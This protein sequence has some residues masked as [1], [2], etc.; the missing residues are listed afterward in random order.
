MVRV[1]FGK[2][3]DAEIVNAQGERG[4]SCSVATEAWSTW[5]GFVYVWVEVA[6]KLVEGD[7]SCLLEAIHTASY[8]KVYKTVSIDV[9]VVV[10]IIPQFLGKHI[11]ED[12]DVLELLHGHAKVEI[13][14][15]D[16]N[17]SGT[18]VGIGDSAIYVQ[19]GI[20]HAHGGRASID[21]V[22]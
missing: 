13:F 17:V 20:E 6:N 2:I 14:Y 22:V 21:R 5:G 19:F 1:F 9:D 12:A 16:A 15:V 7:D 3:F 11:W 8:I 4:G 10:W 18:F